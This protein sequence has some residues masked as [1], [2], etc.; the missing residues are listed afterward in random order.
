MARFKAVDVSGYQP[1]ACKS[2][3]WLALKAKGVLGAIIKLSEGTYYRNPYGTAQLLAAKRAGLKLSGYHFARFVGNAWQARNEANY[4][5]ATAHL[6]GL[7]AGS[8]LVLD[9]E[10]RQGYQSINTQACI[11]FLN[12]VKDAG[13]VPVFYSYSGMRQLWNYEAI[14]RATGAKLWVAAYPHMGAVSQADYGYFPS[15]S[16]H[17]DA[18]QFTDNLFGWGVD[19]TD[20]LTGVFTMAE[21]ITTGGNLDSITFGGINGDQLEITG[22]FA[23][24]KAQGK[25]NA[26]IILTNEKENKEYGRAQVN[27]NDRPDVAKAYPDIPNATRS[28][29]KGTIPYSPEIQGSKCTVIFRYSS[30]PEGNQDFVDYAVPYTFDKAAANL[31]CISTLVYSN[32]LHVSGWFASDLRKSSDVLFMLLIDPKTHK[33]YQ[34]INVSVTQRQD[35][36]LAHPEIFQSLNSGFECNFDYNS[37]MVGKDLQ[38]IMRYTD[39]HE[40]NGHSTDYWFPP[41]NGPSMPVV[42]GKSETEVLVHSFEAN[43]AKDNLISLRF[44]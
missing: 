39:D 1:Q 26:F 2:S 25:N 29:F 9:Y 7:E 32:K 40:G 12:I 24:D 35:V 14:Y 23:S 41:F 19:G 11:A 22:W 37:S 4:A 6:M 8:P 42:D 44:K 28:G 3:W 20:D 18:W 10:L 27:L 13:Y 5:V 31:D 21:K 43:Q 38:V 34:R 30:D 15:I 33:E 16:T 36:Q 17:T